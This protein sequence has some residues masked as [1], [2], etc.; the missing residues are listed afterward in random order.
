VLSTG[1]L[2][3][4]TLLSPLRVEFLQPRSHPKIIGR[5]FACPVVCGAPRNAIVFRAADA[6]RPFV[7]RNAEL[8]AM[9]APQLEEELQK[10]TGDENFSE[11][12][13]ITVQQK[14]AGRR[15]TIDDI[16]AMLHVSSRTLQRRLQDE[17]TSFQRVLEGARHQLARHYLCLSSWI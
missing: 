3:T 9:L 8:L 1:R 6:Q 7:T 14:L 11:Q 2:G 17:R 16:A 5:H 12:V 15:P 10:Q 13:R 4:G